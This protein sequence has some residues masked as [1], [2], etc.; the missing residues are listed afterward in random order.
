[1]AYGYKTLQHWNQWLA[2]HYLGHKLLDAENRALTQV[3]ERHFGK[4]ALLLGVPAQLNLLSSNHLVCQT[5][6]SPLPP[7]TETPD[8]IESDFHDLPFMTGSVDLVLLPHTLDFIEHPRQLLAEACRI[9]KPDGLIAIAGFNPFS[10]W[11]LRKQVSRLKLVPWT[12]QFSHPNQVKKWLNLADFAVEQQVT[13]MFRPPLD[14]RYFFD[15]LDF[16]EKVGTRCF[17]MWGGAYIL[18]A[19]A[20][21]VPLTPIRMKWKQQLSGIRISTTISGHIARRS[22]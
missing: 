6:A 14:Q 18:L 5:L 1:L 4:H 11:G 21:V 16:M 2:H 20:K 12:G 15:K 8:Y 7:K 3:T 17:P 19:R 10:T 9:I 22:K 13:T